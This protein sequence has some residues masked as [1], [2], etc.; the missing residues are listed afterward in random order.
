M[1]L[2]ALN[3]VTGVLH[4]K[5]APINPAEANHIIDAGK[6]N[7]DNVGVVRPSKENENQVDVEIISNKEDEHNDFRA[8]D[9]KVVNLLLI[10]AVVKDKEN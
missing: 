3:N 9:L 6:T 1:P 10:I 8:I 2:V 7:Q 4:H 5:R